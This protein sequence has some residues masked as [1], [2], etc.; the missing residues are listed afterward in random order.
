M[1]ELGDKATSLKRIIGRLRQTLGTEAFDI[2]D[3][4]DGD[5]CAVGI[6]RRDD[7]GLLVY[8]STYNKKDDQY[9]VSLELPSSETKMPYDSAG[10]FENVD[11]DRLESIVRQHLKIY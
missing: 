9:F 7:H 10:T 4:W 5:L 2:V 1:S 8:I 11:F 3:H 6:A